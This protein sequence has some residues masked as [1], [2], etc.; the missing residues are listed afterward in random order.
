LSLADEPVL[1]HLKWS[2]EA[3]TALSRSASSSR[4]W[5]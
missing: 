4:S 5:G 2:S 3:E 1:Y